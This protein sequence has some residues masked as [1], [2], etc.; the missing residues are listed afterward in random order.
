MNGSSTGLAPIQVRMINDSKIVYSVIF[1]VGMNIFVFLL[2]FIV[3]M[4][5]R[6]NTDDTKAITPPI[7]FGI[8]RRIA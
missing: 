3:G 5:N 1:F 4:M 7:L 2:F 8:D 6:I